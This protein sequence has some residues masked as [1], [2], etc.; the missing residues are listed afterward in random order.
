[1]T[2]LQSRLALGLAAVVAIGYD[3]FFWHEQVG[4]NFLWFIVILLATATGILV[5]AKRWH[6]SWA[7]IPALA[8]LGFAGSVALYENEFATGLAPLLSIVAGLGYVGL[9]GFL[10]GLSWHIRNFAFLEHFETMFIGWRTAL[11]S[12]TSGR[13]G[14]LRQTGYGLLIAAPFV[15]IFALLFS[16]ADAIFA[17]WLKRL[18]VWEYGW[19][20]VRTLILIIIGTGFFTTLIK[21]NGSG[22]VRVWT[23]KMP[24]VTVSVV[25]GL[26]NV[27]FAAF[28]AIQ[29]KYYFGQATYVLSNGLTFADYARQGFFD[30][31]RVLVVAAVIVVAIYRS[32]ASIARS[33]LV[34]S[35][36]TVFVAQV[37][38]VAISALKR[39]SLY[40]DMYG[41]TTLR[42]YVEWFIYLTLT[43]LVLAG[44]ALI[45]RFSFRRFAGA[46]LALGVIA[47]MIISWVNVDGLIATNNIARWQYSG[48]NLDTE[49]LGTL[50]LD[51]VPAVAQLLRADVFR[52]LDAAQQGDVA[53]YWESK[54]IQLE[55][56]KPLSYTRSAWQ[57]K[58]TFGQ[59]AV[60][61]GL[62]LQGVVK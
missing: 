36:Q 34:T 13:E 10:P 16:S 25:L 8:S 48:Q 43:V 19:R 38:V 29:I 42:L 58:I 9:V 33:W 2:T 55:K 37:A 52:R 28:V 31:A 11:H 49:Y 6:N 24:V 5:A 20:A 18:N 50:S 15:I 44:I 23:W 14:L 59:L 60:P 39:M 54:Q 22:E 27:L 1:M 53:R 35:L 51:A 12:A 7:A 21:G 47:A 46:V 41:F 57:A 61:A 62:L 40:Q 56:I 32:Y 45:A 26:L 17:D 3:L 30:L 4:N